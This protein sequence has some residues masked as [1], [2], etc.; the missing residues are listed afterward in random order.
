MDVNLIKRGVQKLS[1]GIICVLL[2]ITVP[3]TMERFLK[4]KYHR[5]I[6]TFIELLMASGDP[7]I[8]LRGKMTEISSNVPIE[9]CRLLFTASF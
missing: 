3:D 2:A 8:A 4:K 1:T 9:S 6:I 7:N 5:C